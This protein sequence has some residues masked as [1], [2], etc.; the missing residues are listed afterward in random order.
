MNSD[1]EKVAISVPFF[2]TK[3]LHLCLN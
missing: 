2:L 3:D 1:Q